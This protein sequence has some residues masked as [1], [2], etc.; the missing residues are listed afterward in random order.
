VLLLAEVDLTA[1]ADR[2]AYL[3][4]YMQS[5]SQEPADVPSVA[6]RRAQFIA[7]LRAEPVAVPD[8]IRRLRALGVA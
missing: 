2:T 6:E 5:G 8:S 3:T 1:V 4:A 7:D